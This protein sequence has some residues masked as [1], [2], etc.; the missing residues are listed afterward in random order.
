MKKIFIS[1]FSLIAVACT[2]ND[3]SSNPNNQDLTQINETVSSG[4]WIIT[5]FFDTDSDETS[6]F[7]GYVFSFNNDGSIVANNGSTSHTGTWSITDSNSNDDSNDD[8]DFNIL[9]TSPM[10]FTDLSDDWDVVNISETSIELI[11][12]SGGNGGTDYLTFQRQ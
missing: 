10:E 11:D 2:T 4:D 8:I 7:S 12:V 5:Y 6:N 3:D 1:V 9:F